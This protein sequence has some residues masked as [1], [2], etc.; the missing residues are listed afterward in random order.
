M[1][2]LEGSLHARYP[3]RFRFPME[4]PL[5]LAFKQSLKESQYPELWFKFSHQK[6]SIFN[7]CG[8][9]PYLMPALTYGAHNLGNY[10]SQKYFRWLWTWTILMMLFCKNE[11]LHHTYSNDPCSMCSVKKPKR[12]SMFNRQIDTLLKLSKNYIFFTSAVAMATQGISYIGT[13]HTY[14]ITLWFGWLV[15]C[16]EV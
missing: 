16:V 2:K 5:K 10:Y 14:N 7:F 13:L 11:Q 9:Q 4:I 12:I 8:M 15:G 1:T 3:L 6:E